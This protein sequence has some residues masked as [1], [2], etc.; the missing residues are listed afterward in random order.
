MNSDT[1]IFRRGIYLVT[2][3]AHFTGVTCDDEYDW[4]ETVLVHA[5]STTEASEVVADRYK[6]TG[7]IINKVEEMLLPL[8]C[9]KDS[10]N[11]M[12]KY[13]YVYL[14]P[15]CGNGKQ[16]LITKAVVGAKNTG[17]LLERF[18]T[19]FA[20]S[21]GR[22]NLAS[23]STNIKIIFTPFRRIINPQTTC[24]NEI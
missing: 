2:F 21:H 18:K 15:R 24:D 8:I 19:I 11:D 1:A 14:H 10:S 22:L 13:V 3:T 9:S 4:H 6:Q 23:T 7:L 16:R 12:F 5:N 20:T 17:Q